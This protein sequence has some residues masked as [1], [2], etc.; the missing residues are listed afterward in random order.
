V[1]AVAVGPG[2]GR[3]LGPWPEPGACGEP[4]V[5]S[6]AYRH[7]LLPPFADRDAGTLAELALDV[8]VYI[9]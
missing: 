2:L 3:Q 4:V 6:S 1:E 7:M 9:H 8:K 5:L